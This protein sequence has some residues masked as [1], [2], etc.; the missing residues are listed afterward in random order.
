MPQQ[1]LIFENS[2][3]APVE[4]GI[5]KPAAPNQD[6]PKELFNNNNNQNIT[7]INNSPAAEVLNLPVLSVTN[8]LSNIIGFPILSAKGVPNVNEENAADNQVFSLKFTKDS[9]NTNL[10][11]VD[12][13]DWVA[14]TKI[15]TEAEILQVFNKPGALHIDATGLNYGVKFIN[16]DGNNPQLVIDTNPVMYNPINLTLSYDTAKVNAGSSI[17]AGFKYEFGGNTKPSFSANLTASQNGYSGT[18]EVQNATEAKNEFRGVYIVTPKSLLSSE[19]QKSIGYKP[20]QSK[21][22]I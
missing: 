14:A 3:S 20:E 10:H 12:L 22:K 15:N 5:V 4:K 8:S 21:I 19:I 13:K 17:E 1:D 9:A 18:V 11:T 6:L 7:V 2:L 16:K